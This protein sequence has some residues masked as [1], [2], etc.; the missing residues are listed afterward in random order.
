MAEPAATLAELGWNPFFA[1]QLSPAEAESTRPGRVL[2]VQRRLLTVAVEGGSLE[3][4]LGGRWFQLPPDERP[5]VGDWVLLDPAGTS[6]VRLLERKSLL[7]RVAAGREH[8]VQPI[9]ANVDVLFVV[10]ACNE[11]FNPSRIERYLALAMDAGVAPVVVLTK[12]D[13]AEEPDA[14]VDAVRAL[15]TDVAVELV[16]ARDPDALAGV[17]DWCAV[18]S[19][20]AL[21]GSSGVGKSTLVNSLTGAAVQQTGAAREA[22]AK[23][24]HTTTQRSVHRIP[25][26][27]LLV[28]NPG[29]RELALAEVD[30]DAAA[31]L[32]ADVD[33]L[34][35]QC[36]FRD[37]RHESEPGC[38]VQAALERGDLD[39]R[40]LESYR[41]VLRDDA[42]HRETLAESRA[43]FR[44]FGRHIR[45]I[46]KEK[47]RREP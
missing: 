38:A 44:S 6:V 7:K 4:P 10:S 33:S 11:E 21:L 30:A 13:L 14:F 29:M 42:R 43:R 3:L 47:D 19:T 12:A 37:C 34:A 32:F 36:R 20:V 8:E 45:Q 2:A 46:K 16:D 28:D 31:A 15:K 24:R 22:D 18:G 39:P 5:A 25:G 40:R 23:G 9:A 35:A 41:K 17:R 26:G 1:S 27:G